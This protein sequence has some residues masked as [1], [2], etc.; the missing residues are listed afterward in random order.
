MLDT[1]LANRDYLAGSGR[2]K[3]SIADIAVWPFINAS[4]V[5]GIK[6]EMFP[7]VYRWW[8][9]IDKR[10]AV[11]KGLRVPSGEP[12]AFGYKTIL[13][14]MEGESQW[15]DSERPFMDALQKAREEFRYEYKSP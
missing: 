1:R 7:N 13:K 10:A 6:L 15:I 5:T 2:G 12:F 8:D 9:H 14:K 3:Y 11:Q 4:A